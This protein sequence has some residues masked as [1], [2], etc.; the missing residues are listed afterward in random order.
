MKVLSVEELGAAILQPL[1]SGQRL[2]AG[3][4]PVAAA[5]EGDAPVAA[6]IAR[7]D[8][9]AEGSSPAQLDRRHDT[10]LSSGQRCVLGTIGLT[11]ATEYIRHF[12]P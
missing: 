10:A 4:M 12:R 1:R 9:A 7:F 2:A 3:A 6:L 5:V 8:V 11:V